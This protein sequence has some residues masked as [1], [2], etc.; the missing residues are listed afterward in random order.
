MVDFAHNPE[1]FLGIASFLKSINDTYK[2]G[3]IVGTGDRK[4]EDV[5]L[6]G[7]IS[8]SMFDHVLIHQ[9]KF[10][11]GQ[12]AAHIIALLVKGMKE[13]NPNISW[14]RVPDEMEPLLFALKMKK[15]ENSMIVA[16]SD[17]L[18]EPAVLVKQYQL[19]F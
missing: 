13:E 17:V 15:P 3:I 9:V 4:A 19:T 2:I 6:L 12:T 16:L 11:R 8:A 18:D 7:K 14:Q 1:G 5:T 10:L